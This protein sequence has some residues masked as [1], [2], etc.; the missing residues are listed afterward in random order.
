MKSVTRMSLEWIVL[1]Y[2]IS[3]IPN[4][5]LTRLATSGVH[6]E[7]GRA[8]TGLETLPVSLIVNLVLTY[9]FI[10]LSGWHRDAHGSAR[11]AACACPCPRATPC[12]RAS[13]RRWCCSPCRCRSPS[14][15]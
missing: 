10:W 7:R 5:I 8:L 9:A 3:Y 12:C 6:P 13:A 1:L 11:S 15:T 2:F 4:I 14:P